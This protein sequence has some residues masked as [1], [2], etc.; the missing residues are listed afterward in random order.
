[1]QAGRRER[2]TAN[3]Q[4]PAQVLQL[5]DLGLQRRSLSWRQ[6]CDRVLS[7]GQFRNDAI[8]FSAILQ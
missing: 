3:S 7:R 2:G 1:M 4:T 8:D 5:D 6:G